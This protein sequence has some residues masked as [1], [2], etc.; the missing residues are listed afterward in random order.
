[1]NTLT[2]GNEKSIRKELEI[3][4]VHYSGRFVA[5]GCSYPTLA[6]RHTSCS[7]MPQAGVP[8][9]TYQ[10]LRLRPHTSAVR[11]ERTCSAPCNA[12][13]GAR[14][15]MTVTVEPSPTLLWTSRCPR[16]D[17]TIQAQMA[18]PRPVPFFV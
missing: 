6:S 13:A 5:E 15:S 2:V 4:K 9:A 11:R 7:S 8:V 1:M 12:D 18:N 17:S 16:W 10:V 3:V 14:G